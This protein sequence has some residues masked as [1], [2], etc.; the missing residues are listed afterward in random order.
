MLHDATATLPAPAPSAAKPKPPRAVKPAK[1][2]V[3]D[4][5]PTNVK[6]VQRFLELD[7]YQR[8]V[9]TTDARRALRMA[10]DERPD[11]ILL[12]LMMPHVS[13]LE[14]LDELRAD[15]ELAHIPV[16][17]LTAVTDG[18]TRRDA[19]ERGAT[20]FLN[21]PI[22]PYEL[23]PRVANV[24]AA[25]TYQ[26][27]ILGHSR[28][29]E[30][31]VRERTSDLERAHR[32]VAYCLARAAEYRDN[33]TGFHVLRVGRYARLIGEELGMTGDQLDL[34]EHAAQLHDVGKIGVPDAVLL[35]PDRLTEEEFSLMKKHCG[36]GKRI[37]RQ[38][39][40]EEEQQLRT[41]SEVGAKILD[42]AAS[43]LLVLARK[44]ALSHHEWYD[45]GGYPLGL[46]GEDIPLEGRITAIA[47]VFDALSSRRC[48]KEAMPVDRC[49]EIMEKERGTHFDPTV[50]DAFMRRRQD[51]VGVQLRYADE[52]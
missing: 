50:F 44:I 28:I 40:E 25:K 21:K 20:D 39:S 15:P 6:L 32:E 31:A 24:V 18:A 13:G 33:D 27:Q 47:D 52:E 30:Q 43:P 17:F 36:F 12:D 1:L 4:D 23:A 3:V 48:Y 9:T 22:D 11:C 8:F 16:I 37:L 2:M 34:L 10:R 7:G 41:H 29:L 42:G 45:G 51:V 19:L 46:K 35:K 14:I 26:D 5:E 38:C 49:F